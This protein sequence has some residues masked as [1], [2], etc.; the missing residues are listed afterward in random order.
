MS[1]VIDDFSPIYQGDT[2]VVFA[3]IFTYKDG[4][5]V[6]LSGATLSM[7]MQNINTGAV[8]SCSGVWTID[9]ATNGKA[10]YQWQTAD[11]ATVGIWTL[12]ITITI[13]GLSVHADTK[14][15]VI[16]PII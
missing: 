14:T 1:T 12:Y 11:V 8:Q 9:D 15:L 6:S 16:L 4:T 2:E 3:P 10:H 7:K 13:G 5:P